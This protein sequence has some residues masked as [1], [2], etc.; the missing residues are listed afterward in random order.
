MR[1]RPVLAT[2][3]ALVLA[4]LVLNGCSA[5][6]YTST[7]K[8][9]DDKN[10]E[11]GSVRFAMSSFTYERPGVQPSPQLIEERASALYPSVFTDDRAGLPV[12]IDFK[13]SDSSLSDG[14]K[15][16]LMIFTMFGVVPIPHTDRHDFTVRASVLDSLGERLCEREETFEINVITWASYWPLGLLPVPGPSDL[17]REYRAGDL[18]EWGEASRNKVNNHAAECIAGVVARALKSADQAKLRAAFQERKSRVQEIMVDGKP[19]KSFLTMASVSRPKPGSTFNLLVYQGDVRYSAEPMDQAIVARLDE[20]G[21]WQPVTSYLRSART[22]TRVSALIENNVPVR[23]VVQ[24]PE[25]PPLQDFIDTPDLSGSDRAEVL[26]WSNNVLLEAKNRSLEN[27][28]KLESRDD[29]LTLATQIEKSI[30]DLSAQAEQ[31]KDRAQAMVEKGQGDPAPDRELS[32]LCR[33]RI[34]ILKPVLA[35]VK[36]ASTGKQ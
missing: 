13:R 32:V 11:F 3:L 1:K 35:A 14:G 6:R 20:S 27:V 29:L 5:A 31:A 9:P 18:V 17:P 33:Q 4:A 15:M 23:A 16:L 8:P 21:R 28:L 34:E 30:L 24:T 7:L 36:H 2:G 19:Y 25:T 12:L 26:R 22:L 10:L